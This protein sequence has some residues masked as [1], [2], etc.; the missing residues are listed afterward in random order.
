M[1]FLIFPSISRCAAK[2]KP[3]QI[4]VF[5]PLH[6]SFVPRKTCC[7][8]PIF[9]RPSLPF[10]QRTL[11]LCRK[12]D[13]AFF[14]VFCPFRN[15][16]HTTHPLTAVPFG[17]IPPKGI[18]RIGGSAPFGFS[19]FL[20]CHTLA[21]GSVPAQIFPIKRC[22]DL[23]LNREHYA[24]LRDLCIGQSIQDNRRIFYSV[25]SFFHA[26]TGKEQLLFHFFHSFN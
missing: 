6:A 23:P 16:A 5:F 25:L 3:H 9:F 10:P 8:P 15:L 14:R 19:K 1:F 18:F 26:G 7:A 11:F 21:A 2:N 13:A 22:A 17:G 20:V 24:A 12:S 4:P